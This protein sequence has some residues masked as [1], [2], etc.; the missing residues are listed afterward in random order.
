MKG[1]TKKHVF[2]SEY[3]V[4]TLTI[5]RQIIDKTISI[6]SFSMTYCSQ[7]VLSN[8]YSRL[9]RNYE[10]NDYQFLDNLR[11]NVPQVDESSVSC[12]RPKP[13]NIIYC[14]TCDELILIKSRRHAYCTFVTKYLNINI[15]CSKEAL[16]YQCIL[17]ANKILF[18]MKIL[19]NFTPKYTLCTQ[20]SV[21]LQLIQQ[22]T[23]IFLIK[24]YN[25]N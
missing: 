1:A 15:L 22:S 7:P 13:S 23:Y 9:Y 5:Q 8:V 2:K 10:T 3:K 16:C 25:N 17:L 12:N 14:V 24:R 21:N 6:L 11:R 19:H 20:N 18:Y 4:F